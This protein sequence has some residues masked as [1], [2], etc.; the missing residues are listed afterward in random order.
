MWTKKG[1]G[2]I[3]ALVLTIAQ[4]HTAPLTLIIAFG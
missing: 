1:S 3:S 4:P 2:A